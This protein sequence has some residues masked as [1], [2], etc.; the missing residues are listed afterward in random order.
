MHLHKDHILFDLPQ[1]LHILRNLSYPY[2]VREEFI[3]SQN[4]QQLSKLNQK[5]VSNS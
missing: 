5:V 3:I 1:K 4:I 2:M